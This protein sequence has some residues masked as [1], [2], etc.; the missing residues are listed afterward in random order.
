MSSS[1][2][3]LNPS[4]YLLSLQHTYAQAQTRATT[5]QKPQ[6]P[7]PALTYR[8]NYL[9]QLMNIELEYVAH[10][11]FTEIKWFDLLF[12]AAQKGQNFIEIPIDRPYV[13]TNF[14]VPY[15]WVNIIDGVYA[16]SHSGPI[17]TATSLIP[18][19]QDFLKCRGFEGITP[20]IA[21]IYERIGSQDDKNTRYIVRLS[22]TTHSIPTMPTHSTTP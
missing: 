6:V 16:N 14:K 12:H 15:E 18:Y 5:K 13:L 4:T 19:L 17:Q 10:Y 3:N 2:T 7:S 22:F 21:K 11:L 20:S 9:I 8:L 1:P